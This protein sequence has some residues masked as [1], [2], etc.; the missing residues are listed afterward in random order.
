MTTHPIQIGPW[1]L[2]SPVVL[3]PM[4]GVTDRPFR[5]LCREFGAGLTPTEMLSA[6]IRLWHSEK[7]RL[8]REHAAEDEPRMVQIA[9]SDPIMM[10]QAARLNVEQ[11]ADIIDINMGCPAKK[12]LQK[13]AGSAL[14][15]DE[16]LVE[17]ILGAVVNAVNVPVTLKIRTGWCPRSR[18]GPTIA[19]I[20]EACG[21]K[22]LAVH[23]RTREC[24]FRA[25]VEYDTI[26][27]IKQ[28][29][30]I[31]V[32]ANGDI[33]T[34]HK[35]RYVLD[36]TGADGV[37]LGRAAQG[38]PWIFREIDHYL[39]QGRILPDLPLPLRLASILAHIMHIHGFY[40]D[41]KGVLIARKHVAWYL[42]CHQGARQFR[43][44]FNRLESPQEQL[45]SIQT[46]FDKLTDQGELAA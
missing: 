1:T 37:M 10:A 20:A 40:G 44:V 29:V 27:E 35:A 15:R 36:Y 22:A 31:P 9:G 46:F 6:N 19:R 41:Y 7:S 16:R 45:E 11:G 12:V 2:R 43:S 32:F 3:A 25:A 39:Q 38:R 18:N 23:G 30:R 33:D 21:I 34:P 5:K 8:R 26:G 13:A 42:S 24:A 17:R 28:A 14:L 4:A